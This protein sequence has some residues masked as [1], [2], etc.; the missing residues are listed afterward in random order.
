MQAFTADFRL[1]FQARKIEE[2]K[3]TILLIY[4]KKQHTFN[5]LRY[6][7]LMVEGNISPSVL[8][9][10]NNAYSQAKKCLG[11][12]NTSRNPRYTLMLSG[13]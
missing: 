8:Q 3:R 4:A 1:A 10:K 7:I 2:R 5:K 11:L 13:L 6:Q 9:R 12:K